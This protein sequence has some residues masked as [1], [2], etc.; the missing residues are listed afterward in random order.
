MAFLGVIPLTLS[1]PKDYFKTFSKENCQ[2][3]KPEQKKTKKK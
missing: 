2:Q 1:L 3:T